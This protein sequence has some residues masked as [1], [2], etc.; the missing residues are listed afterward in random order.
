MFAESHQENIL[1]H[2]PGTFGIAAE[3][4]QRGAEHGA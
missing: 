3:L 4:P 2:F 1:R